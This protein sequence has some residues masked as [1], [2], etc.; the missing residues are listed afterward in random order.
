[1]IDRNFIS[2]NYIIRPIKIDE[3][4]NYIK[5]LYLKN[6]A[7][8]YYVQKKFINWCYQSPFKEKFVKDNEFT[9]MASFKK[10]NQE[11][12][13]VV[14]F[15][16]SVS[17]VGGK[18]FST[19]WDTQY[20]N[21]SQ[22]PGL[23]LEVLKQV[24]INT[25]IYCG[26]NLND[27]C[28]RSYMRVFSKKNFKLEVNRKIAIIDGINCDRLFNSEKNKN[29]SEFIMSNL[30]KVNK[31]EVKEILDLSLV[32]EGYWEDHIS[33]F[34]NTSD[35]RKKYLDWRF[36]KHPYMKYNFLSSENNGKKGFAIARIEKIKN[37]NFNA[38]RILDL[39]PKKGFEEDLQNVVLNFAR[40][41]NCVFAD[42]FCSYESN[43]TL[44]KKFRHPFHT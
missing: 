15:I 16:G 41:N 39:M 33:R 35:R 27:R 12:G 6:D 8:C 2:D 30:A 28:L 29:K 14:G 43:S 20:D 24:K 1:M 25:E 5:T 40:D 44:W 34:S 21:F 4:D 10:K 11:I 38:L 37:S 9:I 19:V 7:R 42:F 23:A 13:G 3:I 22:V 18:K 17:F 26:N 32:S 36:F 31:T